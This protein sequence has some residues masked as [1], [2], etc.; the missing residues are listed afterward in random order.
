M[1]T[2]I[3]RTAWAVHTNGSWDTKDTSRYPDA[4]PEHRLPTQDELDQAN[5]DME[6]QADDMA[7]ETG[8]G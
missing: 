1:S 5:A 8:K 4:K 2:H 6:R 7:R 3:P